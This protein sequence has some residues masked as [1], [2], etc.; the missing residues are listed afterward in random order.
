MKSDFQT[1]T[2]L[3]SFFYLAERVKKR[4]WNPKI[5]SGVTGPDLSS[6]R[7][8][9]RK[10]RRNVETLIGRVRR[11]KF[12]GGDWK[13]CNVKIKFEIGDLPFE[14]ADVELNL[15]F[16]QIPKYEFRRRVRNAWNI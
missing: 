2:A 12:R 14:I 13:L 3:F 8:F 11:R 9:E 6:I 1:W 10:V 5:E 15:Q 7:N 16:C 4:I